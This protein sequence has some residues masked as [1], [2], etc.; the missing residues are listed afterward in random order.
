MPRAMASPGLYT[1]NHSPQRFGTKAGFEPA[2]LLSILR[3]FP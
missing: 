2:I 3:F 1:S